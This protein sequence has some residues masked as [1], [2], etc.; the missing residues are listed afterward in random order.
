MS[1]KQ[2]RCASEHPHTVCTHHGREGGGH[3]HTAA[4]APVTGS[5]IHLMKD[6]GW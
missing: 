1:D 5:H 6:L 3:C 4:G 2:L